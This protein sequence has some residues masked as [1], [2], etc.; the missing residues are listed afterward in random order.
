MDFAELIAS[1]AERHAIADL[2]A[3]DNAAALDIDGI[4]VTLVA[5]NGQLAATAEIGGRRRVRRPPAGGEP[6][7]RGVLR[8][9]PRDGQIRRHPPHPPPLPRPRRLRRRPRIPRQPRRNLAPPPRRL[10]PRRPGGR[11]SRRAPPRLRRR[12]LHPCINP[13][14]TT[15]PPFRRCGFQPRLPPGSKWHSGQKVSRGA[16]EPRTE[17]R[18]PPFRGRGILPRCGRKGEIGRFPPL[19]PIEPALYSPSSSDASRSAS[20]RARSKNWGTASAKSAGVVVAKGR[21]A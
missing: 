6:R 16:A 15:M 5:A 18:P 3:E 11:R 13:P 10:P 20:P 4:A 17:P 1:F 7:L 19:P 9:D 14:R 8:Q 21:R 2:A 12:R